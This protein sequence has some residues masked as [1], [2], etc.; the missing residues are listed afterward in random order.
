MTKCR[1]FYYIFLIIQFVS[2]YIDSKQLQSA[3]HAFDFLN[4]SNERDRRSLSPPQHERPQI[5][6]DVDLL[7][8]VMSLPP[9]V[10]IDGGQRVNNIHNVRIDTVPE[11][12][13][14]DF[15]PSPAPSQHPMVEFPV[16][17]V[18]DTDDDGCDV[19]VRVV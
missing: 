16:E 4:M 11:S 14:V 18:F 6:L 5:S 13:I 1:F 3:L 10:L 19:E 17:E 15:P 2:V 9:V 12:P 8:P 7:R